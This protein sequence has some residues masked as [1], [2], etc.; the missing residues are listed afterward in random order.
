MFAELGRDPTDEAIKP[1]IALSAEAFDAVARDLRAMKPK[2]SEHLFQEQ[3]TG[4]V[5]SAPPAKLLSASEIY[6]QRRIS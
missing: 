2:A 4:E 1:Y 6:A 3:A 5:G